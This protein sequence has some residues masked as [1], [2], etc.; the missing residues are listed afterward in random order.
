MAAIGRIRSPTLFFFFTPP[1]LPRNRTAF[2]WM[3]LNKSMMVAA[4]ALPMLKLIMVISPSVAQGIDLSRPTT[5]M[6]CH[7]AKRST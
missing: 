1:H 6:P 4:L 3:A 2:G 7:S 5:S